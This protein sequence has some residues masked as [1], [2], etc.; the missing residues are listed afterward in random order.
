MSDFA[1]AKKCDR[2]KDIE[3]IVREI[4]ETRQLYEEDDDNEFSIHSPE[5]SSVHS[6]TNILGQNRNELT[7]I[8]P[9]ERL[10]DA[11]NFEMNGE[12][13]VRLCFDR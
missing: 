6:Q 10:G 12:P 7:S 9:E 13:I 4:I 3:N 8:L 2:L 1:D 11:D 5:H